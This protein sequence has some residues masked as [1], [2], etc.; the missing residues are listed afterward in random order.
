MFAPSAVMVSQDIARVDE[1]VVVDG[2]VA[3]DETL[4]TLLGGTIKI[5]SLVTTVSELHSTELVK[6]LLHTNEEKRITFGLSGYG[7]TIS[8]I[9]NLVAEMKDLFV[10]SNI[11]ARFVLPREGNIV[12]SVA[13]EKEHV[14]ELVL[15]RHGDEY[16]VG[17]TTCV[18]PFESWSRRDYD[19]PYAD[20]KAGMLPP[21]VSRMVV[22]IALGADSRGKTLLDPFCG[23]GTILGEAMLRGVNVLGSDLDEEV[24]TKA[25]KNMSWLIQEYDMKTN[26]RLFV[27]DAA[28]V[29]KE[30]GIVRIDAVVT[31][32]FM[33][34]SRIGEGK[35]SKPDE[36]ANIVKGLDKL[37]IG[38][39]RQ[40]ALILKPRGIVVM[41]IPSFSVGGRVYSVKKAVDTCENLGYTKLLGPITYG[42]PHAIVQRNFF[43]FQKN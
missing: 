15:I 38:C 35:I 16:I 8:V 5:A 36:I 11:S 9:K 3:S 20:P 6:W 42:R 32:P 28:N 31:E 21:K 19:R 26:A 41:A 1:D 37:Y 2:I 13:I 14:E 25:K 33:G 23:M 4:I 12:S 22:N 24:I 17:K 39:L 7:V 10:S 30:L 40:W 18:Q 43:I 27:S 34:T 29:A